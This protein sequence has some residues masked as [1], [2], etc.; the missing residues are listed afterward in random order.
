MNNYNIHTIPGGARAI[1]I[2]NSS[3]ELCCVSVL[4]RCGSRNEP[5]NYH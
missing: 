5:K 4:V 1:L 3:R 2:P